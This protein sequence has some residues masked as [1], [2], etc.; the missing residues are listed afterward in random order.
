MISKTY[1]IPGKMPENKTQFWILI[2]G[3]G[4]HLNY[5]VKCNET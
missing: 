3:R 4:T 5:E 2:T 1:R